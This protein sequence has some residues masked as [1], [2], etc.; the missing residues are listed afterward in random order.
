[1]GSTPHLYSLLHR[2][3]LEGRN[4]GLEGSQKGLRNVDV[5]YAKP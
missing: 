2:D 5:M 3:L 4:D 1:V